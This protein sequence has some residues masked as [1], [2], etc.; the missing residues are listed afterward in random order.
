MKEYICKEDIRN[1]LYDEDAITMRGVNIINN[2]PAADVRENKKGKWIEIPDEIFA[3]TYKCSSCGEAPLCDEYS[4]YIFS[5]YCPNCG[6]DMSPSVKQIVC[7]QCGG[8]RFDSRGEDVRC[9]NCGARIEE[10]T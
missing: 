4:D 7:S 10:Q 5:P 6:A 9:S 2:Y 8:T 1:K 3:S